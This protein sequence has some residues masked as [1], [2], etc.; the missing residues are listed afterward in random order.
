MLDL[1]IDMMLVVSFLTGSFFVMHYCEFMPLPVEPIYLVQGVTS[2][3]FFFELV[4][5]IYYRNHSRNLQ[6]LTEPP[7]HGQTPEG[8]FTTLTRMLKSCDLEEPGDMKGFEEFITGMVFT[9]PSSYSPV[10]CIS[11]YWLFSPL[12]NAH[13]T[14]ISRGAEITIDTNMHP[15][16]HT[17]IRPELAKSHR[18]VH[19]HPHPHTCR[20]THINMHAY[21]C[22]LI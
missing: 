7:K 12:C 1:S 4:F 10:L 20:N 11:S 17:D 19:T 5:Y 14:I 2:L 3:W 6:W 18:Y 13:K 16:P 8:R 15:F 22:T 9:C 21:I